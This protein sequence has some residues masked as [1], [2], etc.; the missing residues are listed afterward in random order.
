MLFVC[1]DLNVEILCKWTAGLKGWYRLCKQNVPDK[2]HCATSRK[3]VGLIPDGVIG[4][5]HWHNPSSCT[6]AVTEMGNT[7]IFW[8]CRRPVRKADSLTTFMCWLS[9][10]LGSSLSWNPQDLYRPV[11]G[12]E[13]KTGKAD[14]HIQ[15]LLTGVC[16]GSAV[17]GGIRPHARGMDLS[18]KWFTGL[19]KGFLQT[20][21]NADLQHI[22]EVSSLTTRWLT[23]AGSDND[24]H[25][26][27]DICAVSVNAKWGRC[28]NIW[29]FAT[30]EEVLPKQNS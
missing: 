17:H 22:P 26:I 21:F 29:T 25:F 24:L 12:V 1:L 4:I 6:V 30:A 27:I 8:G 28:Y 7:N 9:W 20:I 10:N 16:W 18:V 13:E 15:R 5:F 23:R 19:S 3:V 2:Q 11:T 14:S